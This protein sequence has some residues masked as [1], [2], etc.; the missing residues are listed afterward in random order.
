M[1]DDPGPHM[2]RRRTTAEPGVCAA[3]WL[4]R[5]PRATRFMCVAGPGNFAP[6]ATSRTPSRAPSW[7]PSASCCEKTPTGQLPDRDS[8]LHSAAAPPGHCPAR[9]A[10]CNYSSLLSGAAGVCLA[11]S[12]D[13]PSG[14]GHRPGQRSLIQQQCRASPS[15][16]WSLIH[17][18]GSFISL[19][20]A[21]ISGQRPARR[22]DVPTGQTADRRPL[23]N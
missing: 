1:E 8:P 18:L 22:A 17:S 12:C 14:D 16:Q 2:R 5:R 4:A 7:A 3:A 23:T 21:R 13:S 10:A 9:S 6:S 15:G 11:V 19:R 20:L